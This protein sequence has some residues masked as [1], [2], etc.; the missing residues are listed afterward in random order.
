VA[1]L[2]SDLVNPFRREVDPQLSHIEEFSG[3]GE[4]NVFYVENKPVVSS[5]AEVSLYHIANTTGV[6]LI[7]P[8]GVSTMAA[9]LHYT[10]ELDRGQYTFLSGIYP[11]GVAFKPWNGTTVKVHYDAT[12]YTNGVLGGYL[13]DAIPQVESHI[14]IG[15]QTVDVSP[16]G[17]GTEDQA[18]YLDIGGIDVNT[19][20]F[21]PEGLQL[22]NALIIKE[23]AVKLMYRERRLGIRT[24]E[25]VM[26]RDGDIEINMGNAYRATESVNR[27]MKEELKRMYADIKMNMDA[28]IGIIQ[29]NEDYLLTGQTAVIDYEDPDY[30][31]DHENENLP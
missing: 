4:H 1:I 5:T 27:D 11:T 20:G 15:L 23:A 26:I 24:K 2:I 21:L 30:F 22:V 29:L 12:K 14:R 18:G 31:R 25:N 17:A 7:V 19:I 10:V 8:S 28:G 13:V 6:F 3:D 9:G 16:S